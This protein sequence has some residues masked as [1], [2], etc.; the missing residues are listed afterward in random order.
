MVGVNKVILLG[1]LGHSPEVRK[2]QTGDPV[3]SFSLATTESWRDKATGERKDRTEWHKVVIFNEGLVKVAEQYLK[4]GS[5]VYIE[6]QLRTREYDGRD[7]VKRYATEVVLAKFRGELVLLDSQS[8]RPPPADDPEA[9][10]T[11]R[12][13]PATATA[14]ASTSHL[15][16]D[17]IPF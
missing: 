17:D 14:G 3:A 16:D 15:I 10:G 7:G 5:K 11:H 13:S 4:K 12:G 1:N 9:Y 6:G 8:N 2:T